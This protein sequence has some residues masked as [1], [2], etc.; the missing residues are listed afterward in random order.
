MDYALLL[1]PLCAGAYFDAVTQVVTDELRL[2]IPDAAPTF[3]RLGGIHVARMTLTHDQ[4]AQVAR[5]SFLQGVFRVEASGWHPVALPDPFG[6]PAELVWG[7]KYAGKTNELV[8]QLAVNVALAHAVLPEAGPVKLLDPTAGRGTTL[9][10]AARYGLQATGIERDPKALGDLQRNVKR[11]MKLRR[12][13]YKES[14]GYTIKKNAKDEGRFLRYRFEQGSVRLVVGDSRHGPRLLAGE[15]F[16][17]MVADL[18]YGIQHR[19]PGGRRNPLQ[20]LQACA[21]GW[22]RLL[23]PGGAMVLVYNAFMPQREELVRCME[24]QGLTFAGVV[25]PHRMSESI[26]RELAV[27]RRLE[28]A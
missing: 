7:A 8:T 14:S 6:L 22:A 26:V 24:A 18:P 16:P 21:P 4:L 25:A 11:Q 10:W 12:V 13:K 5:A 28:G 3:E 9:L 1:S 27:F 2:W 15:R 17:L 20:N 19:G 23:Q